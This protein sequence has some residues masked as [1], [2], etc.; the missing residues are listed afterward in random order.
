VRHYRLHGKWR[1]RIVA[2]LKALGGEAS[3]ADLYAEIQRQA[4]ETLLGNWRSTVRQCLQYHCPESQSYLSH[5]PLFMHK[6]RGLWALR[7]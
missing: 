6:A 3:L 7:K 2:A 5:R 1:P 4:N